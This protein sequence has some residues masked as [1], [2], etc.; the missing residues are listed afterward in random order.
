MTDALNKCF[1]NSTVITGSPQ[2]SIAIYAASTPPLIVAIPET[3]ISISSERLILGIYSFTINGAS[4]CPRK[5][6]P[7]H[8]K[9]SA[10]E[11][12]ISFVKH[13]PMNHTIF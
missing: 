4:V 2:P 12:L 6:L 3:I 8:D 1:A 10:P 13:Q 11:M 9:D 7:A 5:I